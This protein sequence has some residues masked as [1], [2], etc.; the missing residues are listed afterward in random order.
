MN[1]KKSDF[2]PDADWRR[3]YHVF[4]MVK[5]NFE[6]SNIDSESDPHLVLNK[7]PNYQRSI[8]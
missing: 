4:C 3:I 8:K 6:I 1:L 5:E 2:H 7:K